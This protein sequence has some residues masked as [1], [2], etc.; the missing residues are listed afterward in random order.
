MD[1]SLDKDSHVECACQLVRKARSSDTE[2]KEAA[3]E[4]VNVDRVRKKNCLKETCYKQ[5]I[6]F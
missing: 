6:T 4:S 3:D 1:L 5:K 2:E